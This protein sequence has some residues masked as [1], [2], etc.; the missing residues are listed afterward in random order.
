MIKWATLAEVAARPN[1]IQT[2]RS[3]AN[4]TPTSTSSKAWEW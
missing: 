3:V 4:F 2:G 1:G